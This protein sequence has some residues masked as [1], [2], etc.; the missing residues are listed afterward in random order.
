MP[1]KDKTFWPELRF[2]PINLWN[3]YPSKYMIELYNRWRK[4]EEKKC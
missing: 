3:I 2:G 1:D 4:E